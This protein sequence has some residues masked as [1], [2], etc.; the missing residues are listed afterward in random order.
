MGISWKNR[1]NR[2][3]TQFRIS[4]FLLVQWASRK[5]SIWYQEQQLCYIQENMKNEEQ[6]SYSLVILFKTAEFISL[7]LTFDRYPK[8]REVLLPFFWDLNI[9]ASRKQIKNHLLFIKRCCYF[10]ILPENASSLQL[11]MFNLDRI[12]SHNFPFYS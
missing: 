11:M 8:E 6:Y 9:K 12:V 4:Q 7:T 1:K 2:C 10:L 3:K 5:L